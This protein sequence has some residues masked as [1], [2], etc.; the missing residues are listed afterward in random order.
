M[1]RP[2]KVLRAASRA[3]SRRHAY[4]AST[5][6]ALID[7]ATRLFSERG[8]AAT[9]L[10]E[11]VAAAK[12]TKGALYHHYRGKQALFEA[13]FDRLEAD[14]TKA[15]QASV[16]KEEDPWQ[17]ALAG[18]HAFVGQ[19][20]QP[21]YRR[22]VLQ[23]GPVVLGFEHWRETEERSTYGLVREI[24][25]DL[26]AEYGV[27][28]S[29]AETFTQVF[30]GAMRTAGMSVA[31]ADDPDRASDEVEIVIAAVLAGLRQFAEAGGNLTATIP[32]APPATS[33]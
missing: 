22:V 4:S 20:K 10:D 11:V 15:I 24:V 17:R 1:T 9:S 18:L 13:V 29:L 7:S 25:M 2:A 8:Y 31:E 30:Y 3:K 16:R 26:V 32:T 23:E 27:Q 19:S 12:L 14:S 6:K 28:G 5:R 33:S 21:T